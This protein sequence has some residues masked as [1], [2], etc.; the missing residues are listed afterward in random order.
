MKGMAAL[1]SGGFVTR[2]QAYRE[3]G[4]LSG[5]AE[6]APSRQ[7]MDQIGLLRTVRN[8]YSP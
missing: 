4:G 7:F 8:R 3:P 2:A 1:A 5:Q 6:P